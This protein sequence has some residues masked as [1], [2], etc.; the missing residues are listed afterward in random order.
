V[1]VRIST[2]SAGAGEPGQDEGHGRPVDHREQRRGQADGGQ[3]G[4]QDPARARTAAGA[5]GQRGA[6]QPARTDGG[7]QVAV[8]VRAEPDLPGHHEQQHGLGSVHHA[9]GDVGADQPQRL[10]V[11]AERRGAVRDLTEQSGGPIGGARRA[12]DVAG[13]NGQHRESRRPK[14]SAFSA[15]AVAGG[16]SSS[17]SPPGL[18]RR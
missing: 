9:A 3:L 5:V 12:E 6:R 2:S 13:A 7:E 11:G 14:V 18:A 1:S 8:P 16:P 10:G 17:R 15:M 4:G